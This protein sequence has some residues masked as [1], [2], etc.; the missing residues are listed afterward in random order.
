MK[1][2]VFGR[3]YVRDFEEAASRLPARLERTVLNLPEKKTSKYEHLL[4]SLEAACETLA[5]ELFLPSGGLKPFKKYAFQQLMMFDC[6]NT[7]INRTGMS[8]HAVTLLLLLGPRLHI[9]N[10]GHSSL[11]RFVETLNSHLTIAHVVR[12]RMGKTLA[13]YAEICRCLVFFPEADN[14][15]LYTAHSHELA[16]TCYTN[17]L[18]M[19]PLLV[20]RYNRL[21]NEAFVRRKHLKQD[22]FKYEASV[23]ANKKENSITVSFKRVFNDKPEEREVM[24]NIFKSKAYV[25]K[26]VSITPFLSI[27]FS[28]KHE[29]IEA[30]FL[31]FA[32]ELSVKLK[33]VL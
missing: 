19:L 27:F 16:T 28:E 6:I 21:E 29:R 12:R 10:V 13:L 7:M 14:D 31:F 9:Q 15:I 30:C 3:S 23:K 32:G 33:Q 4:I 20:A 2:S 8:E 18:C 1:Y 11:A 5:H 17:V 26:E 25:V 24:R 22:D